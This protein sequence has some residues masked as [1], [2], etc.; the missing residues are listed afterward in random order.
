MA[1]VDGSIEEQDAKARRRAFESYLIGATPPPPE[2]AQAPLLE[3][4]RV[5]IV[6]V[7][8]DAQP[9]RMLAVLVGNVTRHPQHVDSRTI[10]TSQLI[11]LDRNRQWARTFNRVYRLG[12]RAG[13]AFDSEGEA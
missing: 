11:F 13:D 6:Q 3:N 1:L 9:L 7:K 2:M 5:L 10:R 12:E 8:R 4:W